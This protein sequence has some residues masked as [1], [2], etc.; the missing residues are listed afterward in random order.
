[1]KSL[2]CK[3]PRRSSCFEAAHHPW[4]AGTRS[5]LSSEDIANQEVMFARYR[6]MSVETFNERLSP[7]TSTVR[8]SSDYELVTDSI[9]HLDLAEHHHQDL[10]EMSQ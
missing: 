2:L 9:V 1:M 10:C 4:V 6:E 5:R 3:A 7:P 8:L